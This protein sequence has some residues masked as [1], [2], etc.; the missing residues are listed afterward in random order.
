MKQIEEMERNKTERVTQKERQSQEYVNGENIL[1]KLDPGI[2]SILHD[3]EK[4]LKTLLKLWE[5]HKQLVTKY[6]KLEAEGKTHPHFAHE[7]KFRWQWPKGYAA[8]AVPSDLELRLGLADETMDDSGD[9]LYDIHESFAKL[10]RR[11]ASECMEFIKLHQKACFSYLDLEC[12]EAAVCSRVQDRLVQWHLEHGRDSFQA[13]N[14]SKEMSFK[15]MQLILR[16][17][18]P[19]IKTRLDRERER[20]EKQAKSLEEANS[21]FQ[22]MDTKKVL[23]QAMIEIA[24]KSNKSHSKHFVPQDGAISF[25]LSGDQ[26]FLTKHKIHIGWGCP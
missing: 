1:K 20:H 9:K 12:E 11:H 15:Y 24:A 8:Q 7:M 23:T 16:E 14:Y 22:T 2:R 10:R 21:K 25:L 13:M 5:T 6:E 3:S 19:R 17:E 26:E 18:K 4:Q